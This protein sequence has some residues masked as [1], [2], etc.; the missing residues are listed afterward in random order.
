MKRILTVAVMCLLL[1]AATQAAP[2]SLPRQAT[3]TFNQ[4]LTFL[5]RTD[6]QAVLR[7]VGAGRY[8][9][10][11]PRTNGV[12]TSQNQPFTQPVYRPV[13]APVR[14]PVAVPVHQPVAAPGRRHSAVPARR[15]V[16]TPAPVDDD[17]DASRRLNPPKRYGRHDNGNH[18]GQDNGKREGSDVPA[19]SPARD[20]DSDAAQSVADARSDSP[21]R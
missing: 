16:V 2:L 13:T 19:D 17:A 15:A 7:L 10:Y 5:N 8:L 18:F 3:R 1:V 20:D 12:P 14:R 4:V 6:V 9:R 11:I 21:S